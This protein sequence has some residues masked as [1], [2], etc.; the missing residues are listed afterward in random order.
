VETARELPND[1]EDP[2]EDGEAASTVPCE[3]RQAGE[4]R[5][6]QIAADASRGDQDESP[7]PESKHEP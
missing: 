6:R 7:D 3:V 2:G 1:D 4:L 5:P